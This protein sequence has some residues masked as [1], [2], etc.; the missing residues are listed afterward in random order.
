MA[1]RASLGHDARVPIHRDADPAIDLATDLAGVP[2]RVQRA[3][4]AAA[5]ETAPAAT[6]VDA[7]TRLDD[8]QAAA[9]VLG[10]LARDS[11]ADAGVFDA[12]GAGLG[13]LSDA[14]LHRVLGDWTA[15]MLPAA[16]YDRLGEALA[17]TVGTWPL[18]RLSARALADRWLDRHAPRARDARQAAASAGCTA[19][20]DAEAIETIADAD[21]ATLRTEALAL[22][23]AHAADVGRSR[24]W[25]D[26]CARFARDALAALASVPKSLSQA[27]AEALLA[28]RVYADPGRCF[29]ELLQNA[30][31]AGATRWHLRFD[32]TAGEIRAWHDGRS[33]DVL[34]AVGV[35]SIG[36]SAKR[37]GQIG[38][39]GVGFKSVY[40][41]TDRPQIHSPPYRFEI[42]DVSVPRALAAPPP[43]AQA[44]G[45]LLVL[46]RRDGPRAAGADDPLH[47]RADALPGEALLMLDHVREIEVRRGPRCRRWHAPVERT[48]DG[49]VSIR[50]LEAADGVAMRR[51]AVAG[52]RRTYAG[53]RDVE[54]ARVTP[55]CVAIALDDAGRPRPVPPEAPTIYC[56]LP[57]GERSGL[58][59]LVHAHFD[60][61]VDRERI[62]LDAPWNRWALRAAG[63]QL[64]RIAMAFADDDALLDV[65][66][67]PTELAHAAF[68]SVLAGL[69]EA[70]ADVRCLPSADGGRTTPGQAR[71]VFDPDVALALAGVALDAE[72]GRALAPLAGRRAD[73][74]RALGARAFDARDVA[75]RIA[76]ASREIGGPCPWLPD[77]LG[78]LF[79]AV[80]ADIAATGSLVDCPCIPG[81]DDR[82]HRPAEIHLADGALHRIYANVRPLID[83]RWLAAYPRAAEA[84]AALGVGTLGRSEFLADLAQP[85]ARSALIAAGMDLVLEALDELSWT[86]NERARLARLPIFPDADG[87]GRPLVA[88]DPSERVW[89]A[90]KGPF[91]AW[92][93]RARPAPPHFALDFEGRHDALLTRLGVPHLTVE[94]W[95]QVARDRAPPADLSG[96]H[97]ALEH[98]I[99]DL[100]P[101]TVAALL[102]APIFADVDG[103]AR[104]GRGPDAAALPSDDAIVEW[105]RGWPWLDAALRAYS[106]ARRLG[107]PRIDAA[108]VARALA[109]GDDALE[110][111]PGRAW[112]AAG[113]PTSLSTA[114]LEALAA[115]P[116]WPAADGPHAALDCLR[117]ISPATAPF[118]ADAYA[119]WPA[120]PAAADAALDDAAA[121]GLGDRIAEADPPR[122]AV[123]LAAAGVPPNVER[124]ALLAALADALDDREL[125]PLRS[126]PVFADTDGGYR[127]PAGARACGPTRALLL[128]FGRPVLDEGDEAALGPLLN[129]LGVP[130]ISP[131]DLLDLLDLLDQLSRLDQLDEDV[132]AL[133]RA[134][135]AA[136]A[137]V[138]A[139][140][141]APV[142]ADMSAL[143]MWPARDG[144]RRSA[145]DLC[146]PTALGALLGEAATDPAWAA[147]LVDDDA[148]ADAD[149][150]AG[151]LDFRPPAALVADDARA[152]AIADAPLTDQPPPYD[153]PAGVARLYA[154]L[155]AH[156][157]VPHDVPLVVAATGHLVIGGRRRADV[158]T[159]VLARS[160]D[161]FARLADPIWLEALPPEIAA[162]LPPLP[163]RHLTTALAARHA[164]SASTT[165]ASAAGPLTD[166]AERARLYRWLLAR[167]DELEAD[168]QAR[169]PLGHAHIIATAGG[170]LRAPP[171]LMPAAPPAEL[172]VDAHPADEVPDA[173]VRALHRW[174]PLDRKRR[175]RLVDRVV[176]A[177]AQTVAAGGPDAGAQSA[178]LLAFLARG[179][180]DADDRDD[181]DL[182]ATARRHKLARRLRVETNQGFGRPDRALLP[183]ADEWTLVTRFIDPPPRISGRY[184]VAGADRLLVACGA[185]RTLSA[186][187]LDAALTRLSADDAPVDARAAL[188]AYIASALTHSPA[189][190]GSLDLDR[191]PWI[192]DRDG[193][194]HI[195]S[196]LHWPDEVF[197]SVLAADHPCQPHPELVLQRGDG[198]RDR[199]AFRPL[200]DA[201]IENVAAAARARGGLDDAALAWLE[202]GLVAGRL[203]AKTV[204]AAL[205]DWPCLVD[206]DGCVR[207]PREVFR[208]DERLL[209]GDDRGAW[210]AGDRFRRLATALGIPRR[211]DAA[212]IATWHADLDARVAEANSAR[213]LIEADPGLFSRL[214]RS[215]ARLAE[216]DAAAPRVLW[217]AAWSASGGPAL[218]RVDDPALCRPMPPHLE[219]AARIAGAPV[220]FPALPDD[221]P[222]VASAWL[223]RVGL[224][225]LRSRWRETKSGVRATGALVELPADAIAMWQR[226][227]DAVREAG[228]LSMPAL[229]VQA[230]EHLERSG[231]LAGTP[232]S[233]PV[234]AALDPSRTAL[235]IRAGALEAPDAVAEALVA[236][237]GLSDGEA[238]ILRALLQFDRTEQMRLY[239]G[240]RPAAAARAPTPAVIESPAPPPPG[241]ESPRVFDRL[242][243]WWRDREPAADAPADPPP[244]PRRKPPPPRPAP[245]PKDH[246]D[247]FRGRGRIESQVRSAEN[248]LSDREGPSAFGFATS[249]ARLPAPYQYAPQLIADHFDSGTQRWTPRAIDPDWSTGR[250]RD[251]D[252]SVAFRGRVPHGDVSLPVP[253]YGRVL[254]IDA[255][256]AAKR[257]VHRGGHTTLLLHAD[258]DVHYRI[259]LARPP[260]IDDHR[261]PF[262]PSEAPA[263]LLRPTAPDRE[264]PDEVHDFVAGVLADRPP[265]RQ[266]LTAVR[267]FVRR[268]Y[269]YDP[270][271]LEDERVAAWL[272]RASRG[273]TNRHLAALHAGA[274]DRHLGAG[275][276][277]ELNVLACE[278]LRRVEIP[279]AIATGWTL[280][281]GSVTE[282]DHLWAV[283]LMPTA[284]GPRWWPVDASTT[285]DGRPLHANA[286]PPGP[287]R[288]PPRPRGTPPKAP[289]WDRAPSDGGPAPLPARA[290]ARAIRD[291][292]RRGDVSLPGEL[293][294][295]AALL[296]RCRSLLAD[297]EGTRALIALVAG[298]PDD[299]PRS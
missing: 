25:T 66:P 130:Q 85:P 190:R 298:K 111:D 17:D 7:V 157:G 299:D 286:R 52:E 29:F 120:R 80:G 16:T 41:L 214:P 125:A 251:D 170:T 269:R 187:A 212:A 55:I 35:L 123:D 58:R 45:T 33:F 256:P 233:Y 204:R 289:A 77:A 244:P 128:R 14:G 184:E 149:A 76:E 275:V 39:F 40:A 248:W 147:H 166:A 57:T 122:L 273:R 101:R 142:R 277:Y 220:A 281:R 43:G 192:P 153:T 100:A 115:A 30:D 148:R 5:L 44:D 144:I 164:T 165:D 197:A 172:G 81:T 2:W 135:C 198:L 254:D 95:A 266:R 180:L 78:A 252:F 203:D 221:A 207:R 138:L 242:R 245:S 93:I 24:A 53:L 150:L 168:E 134:A 183:N 96:L 59:C 213:T 137:V 188:A 62:A 129:R 83:P 257:V 159:L 113:D 65:L 155:E 276:C 226:R 178:A 239:L 46:P 21:L 37:R 208:R 270:S 74:V 236:D 49:G 88:D 201:A 282:P 293:R 12:I 195:A 219:A 206:D 50:R 154:A 19:A 283:A 160:S 22:A 285:R 259:A 222:E 108:D 243:R 18:P 261:A 79:T 158:D 235:W 291:A 32:D 229:R 217:L 228:F 265:P 3:R 297:P 189:L 223:A 290:L 72:D 48:L 71:F 250:E 56:Y 54:R 143:A 287:W 278:L 260:A 15:S 31:D 140:A 75:R 127:S 268:H 271:Y 4:L 67:C 249:P 253:M 114:A 263:T 274:D 51:Y 186:S 200:G 296:S 70:V 231:E 90:P 173:L 174:F 225:D 267:D 182:E 92:L 121:L 175:A 105:W 196:D 136:D 133:M 126:A 98:V 199:L 246:G 20:I 104:P 110:I 294:R 84:A 61:P 234:D 10:A 28:R 232:I 295:E 151:A 119:H 288:A 215:L 264:L 103:H 258:A 209:F 38:F 1:S 218:L 69:R 89:R 176:E 27:R 109:A 73:V 146:R 181:A 118:I 202:A 167:A 211:A 68:E 280:D 262:A 23:A 238:A 117:R 156:G 241:S 8:A 36:L 216:A 60:V 161:V 87:V 272:R 139:T 82:L 193:Q 42:A 97:A 237:L 169:G 63:T 106:T 9:F 171:D 194:L 11:L 141:P 6:L 162:R 112:L 255:R 240:D 224:G 64:G 107:V 145:T 132:P 91:G 47:A 177:H 292:A 230:V 185:R 86:R 210:S 284:D 191:R 163:A 99:D 94:I 26:R 131:I 205:S 279:A 152:R 179:V 102:D 116:I 13:A 34:D 124:R 227:L 247:W